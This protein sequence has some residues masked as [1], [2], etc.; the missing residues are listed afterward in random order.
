MRDYAPPLLRKLGYQLELVPCPDILKQLGERRAEIEQESGRKLVLVG[1]SAETG[2]REEILKN[3]R[4]KLT[5][6]KCDFIVANSA[7][8]AFGT[9]TH[10][11]WILQA[12]G[13]EQELELADK[14]VVADRIIT[15]AKN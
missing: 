13:E 9:D 2:D 15:A 12:N 11:G 8:E 10:C 1:F 5:R 6:K 7:A 14:E 3:S 4:E